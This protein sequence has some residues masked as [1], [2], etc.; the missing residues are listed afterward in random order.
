MELSR[1]TL[2]TAL[3]VLGMYSDYRLNKLTTGWSVPV[4]Y[5]GSDAIV[6]LSSGGS[7]M[8]VTG[9]YSGS[10]MVHLTANYIAD[11]NQSGTV[12]TL[13]EAGLIFHSTSPVLN[14]GPQQQQ[15][16]R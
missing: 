10:V 8:F 4:K 7:R 11:Y 3:K 2:A 9:V 15:I 5:G 16:W 6:Y 13:G 12:I 1:D 14:M